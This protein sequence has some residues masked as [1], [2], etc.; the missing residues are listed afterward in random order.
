MAAEV[1]YLNLQPGLYQWRFVRCSPQKRHLLSQAPHIVQSPKEHH[2]R[3]VILKL[4][5][6]HLPQ[7]DLHRNA[8]P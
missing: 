5:R 6:C 8:F 1:T 4:L 3:R 2:G 7:I